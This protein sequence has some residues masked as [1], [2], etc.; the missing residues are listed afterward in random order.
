M[1]FLTAI[2]TGINTFPWFFSSFVSHFIT[3]VDLIIPLL[4]F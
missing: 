1:H 4:I 3:S 2:C